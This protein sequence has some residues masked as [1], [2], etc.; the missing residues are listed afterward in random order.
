MKLKASRRPM[1][2]EAVPQKEA[3]MHRPRKRDKVVY[4]TSVSL[5]PNS[6]ESCGKVNATPY[7]NH[8]NEILISNAE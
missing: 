1:I 4:L 5:T 7:S 8:I 3:P 6:A 2:S